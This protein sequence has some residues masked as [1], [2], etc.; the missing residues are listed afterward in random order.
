M[1][2]CVCVCERISEYECIAEIRFGINAFIYI[3]N[4]EVMCAG[5]VSAVMMMVM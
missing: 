5:L 1:C 2:V 3:D 4:V